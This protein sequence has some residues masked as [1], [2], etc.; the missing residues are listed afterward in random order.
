MK[1]NILSFFSGNSLGDNKTLNT[2]WLLFRLHTGLSIA[3]HA[4]FPKMRQITAPGWF[5]EQVAGLGF[6]F[7][8]PSFWAALAAWGEFIGGL[9][10]AFGFLTRFSAL[11]LAFQFFVIAFLWYD[12]PEPLT[13]MYFQQTL[14]WS[15]VLIAAGGAGRYSIDH[16]IRQRKKN[17]LSPGILKTAL[18]LL[19]LWLSVPLSAQPVVKPGSFRKAEGD[20]KGTLTYL[21]YTS[22]KS[23]TMPVKLNISALSKEAGPWL[24]T[25]E[26]PDEP[27]ANGKDSF[28][29]SPDGRNVNRATVVAVRKKKGV[30]YIVAETGGRDGNENRKALFRFTYEISRRSLVWKKEVRFEGEEQFFQRN[31][32]RFSR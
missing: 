19:L 15:F 5:E 24:L 10:I 11:Q 8:S 32:Y 16:L 2:G 28:S 4:G 26:F 1:K 22:G 7:P 31:E 6:N 14:F 30:Q 13:G 3:I 18:P 9:L 17:R 25:V 12:N 27:R 29:I 21:D 20:W 23:H